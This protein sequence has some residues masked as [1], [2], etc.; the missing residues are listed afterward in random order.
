[1]GSVMREVH[2]VEREWLRFRKSKKLS[3]L[4]EAQQRRQDYLNSIGLK[5]CPEYVTLPCALMRDLIATQTP[6]ALGEETGN[7]LSPKDSMLVN[8]VHVWAAY[9]QRKTIYEVDRPLGEWAATT[10]WPAE[11]PTA[12]LSLPSVCPVLAIRDK[13]G[14]EEYFAAT[15]DLATGAEESGALELR[16]SA[17]KWVREPWSPIWILDLGRPTLSECAEAAASEARTRGAIRTVGDVQLNELA[18][19]AL[20]ILLYLSLN[21]DDVV[22]IDLAKKLI[23]PK[24]DLIHPERLRDLTSPSQYRIGSR[25]RRANAFLK[26]ENRSYEGAVTRRAPRPHP[27]RAHTHLYWGGQGRTQPR[28]RYLPDTRVG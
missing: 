2:T 12:A 4:N 9:R 28:V 21:P 23:K 5:E 13:W 11:T 19:V 6:R 18:R 26:V 25:F 20:N 3:L 15:Y 27:R 14:L 16:L 8:T 22:P 7:Y 1:M 10:P 24:S 17:R